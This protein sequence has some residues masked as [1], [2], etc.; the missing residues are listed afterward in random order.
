VTNDYQTTQT[1]SPPNPT[2]AGLQYE[3]PSGLAQALAVVET[4]GRVVPVDAEAAEALAV[5]VSAVRRL[6]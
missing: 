2:A 4:P 6:A 1:G 5:I 3:M